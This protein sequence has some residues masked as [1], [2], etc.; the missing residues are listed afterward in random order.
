[1]E[2][3]NSQEYKLFHCSECG[4]IF[5]CS[6]NANFDIQTGLT[7]YTTDFGSI[8]PVYD[9]PS[10][11]SR[12]AHISQWFTACYIWICPKCGNINDIYT[13]N[14]PK[15]LQD[16]ILR[17]YAYI[18]KDTKVIAEDKLLLRVLSALRVKVDREIGFETDKIKLIKSLDMDNNHLYFDSLETDKMIIK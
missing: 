18:I 15:C 9:T 3:K 7:M 2:T 10:G 6:P 13:K 8:I 11:L 1:M 12:S 14:I 5:K 17:K 16:E 4:T